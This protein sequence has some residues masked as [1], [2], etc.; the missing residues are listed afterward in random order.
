MRA[1]RHDKFRHTQPLDR[2]RCPC[3]GTGAKRSFFFES[4]LR[5]DGLNVFHNEYPFLLGEIIEQSSG[6]GLQA[7]HTYQYIDI[8]CIKRHMSTQGD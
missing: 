7:G 2:G 8:G 5:D 6:T 1:I 3:A 4:H